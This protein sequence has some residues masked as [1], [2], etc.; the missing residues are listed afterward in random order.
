MLTHF[1]GGYNK[2]NNKYIIYAISENHILIPREILPEF[3]ILKMEA[4]PGRTGRLPLLHLLRKA[5]IS[6][7][8]ERSLLL[9]ITLK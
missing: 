8:G 2:P 5:R 1:S 7:S 3:I 6:L 9:Q 4:S